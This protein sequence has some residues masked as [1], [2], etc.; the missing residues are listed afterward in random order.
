MERDNQILDKLEKWIDEYLAEMEKKYENSQ[1]AMDKINHIKNTVIL[2]KRMTSNDRMSV[3]ATKF[4][5]I[6]R[7]KQLELLGSFNDGAL[8]HHNVGEDVITRA[9][10]KGELDISK[11]LNAIRQVIQYHGRQ[12]FIPYKPELDEGVSELID[13]V[14][15]VDEIENGCIGATGYLIREAEEDAKGYRKN[16]PDLDMKSVSPEVWEFF[17]KGEKFDKMKFCKT[18]ADYTLFASVLA[19]QALKGNDREIA[20]AAMDLKC[21]GYESALDGYKDIFSKLIDSKYNEKAFEILRE[22]YDK[23]QIDKKA[24]SIENHENHESHDL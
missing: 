18:Y 21:N 11:E 10:F 14:S 24:P 9:V 8:L 23:G 22:F 17:S 12:K 20:K 13:I 6:G 16:S 5:D 1:A 15:R 4:H 7:F 19:I 3:I 2:T